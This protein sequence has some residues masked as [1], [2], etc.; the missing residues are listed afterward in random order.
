MALGTFYQD[1][2]MQSCRIPEIAYVPV[3]RNQ[4]FAP[5]QV[6]GQEDI[7]AIRAR[8]YRAIA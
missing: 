5:V 1:P 3:C 2:G 8:S 7:V 6:P 4:M